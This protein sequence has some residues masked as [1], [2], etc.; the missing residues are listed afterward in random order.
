MYACSSDQV[1]PYPYPYLTRS[2]LTFFCHIPYIRTYVVCVMHVHMHVC[3]CM[4][5]SVVCV[6]VCVCGVCTV[7]TCQSSTLYIRT[8]IHKLV[9]YAH[10]ICIHM[11]THT[12]THTHTHICV[13][14]TTSLLL[15]QEDTHGTTYILSSTPSKSS[16][17]IRKEQS[18]LGLILCNHIIQVL[19]DFFFVKVQ[20]PTPS[21][22]A[23]MAAA[24]VKRPPSLTL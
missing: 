1:H 19:S 11:H 18:R 24:I 5:V 22:Y 7:R 10:N 4:C 2:T 15:C 3:V 8:Y 12:H 14:N 9:C 20:D 21:K 16:V 23:T 17:K 6:C 13:S